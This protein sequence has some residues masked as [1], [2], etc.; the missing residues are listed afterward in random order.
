VPHSRVYVTSTLYAKCAFEYIM[1]SAQ[2]VILSVLFIDGSF[3][4][5]VLMRINFLCIGSVIV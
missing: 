4:L 2:V 5:P 1:P 3:R